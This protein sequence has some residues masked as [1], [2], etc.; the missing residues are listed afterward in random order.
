[1]SHFANDLDQSGDKVETGFH[2]FRHTAG[3]AEAA[4]E[5]LAREIWQDGGRTVAAASTQ[6]K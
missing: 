3:A 6:V 5:T 2:L 4:T 1:M